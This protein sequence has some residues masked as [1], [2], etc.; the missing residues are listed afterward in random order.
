MI[1]QR[2]LCNFFFLLLLIP[3]SC[4]VTPSTVFGADEEL[5]F[6]KTKNIFLGEAIQSASFGDDFRSVALLQ[7]AYEQHR[8]TDSDE[9]PLLYLAGRYQA[10]G[11]VDRA[12]ALYRRVAERGEGSRS[13]QAW[14][15]FAK[16]AID[17]ARFDMAEQA[18]SHMDRQLD[19]HQRVEKGVI[20]SLVYLH[21]RKEQ[22]AVR[23]LPKFKND[24]NWSIYQR[25]NIAVTLLNHYR[26]RRGA[27]ILAELGKLDTQGDPDK[28]AIRD[29]ANLALGYSL[30]QLNKAKQARKYLS[31]INLNTFTANQALLGMGWAYSAENNHR[32]ALV[33]WLELQK[34]STTIN[35]HLY[36]STLA[37]P[38]GFGRA[39]AVSRAAEA[40][41][42]AIHR[43]EADI[44]AMNAAKEEIRRGILI[45]I[46]KAGS[47]ADEFSWTNSWRDAPV[48]I[49]IGAFVPL[50]MESPVFLQALQEYRA[51]LGLRERYKLMRRDVDGL[52]Q[53]SFAGDLQP[54]IDVVQ[55]QYRTIGDAF[56]LAINEAEKRLNGLAIDVLESHQ[57]QLKEYGQQARFGL[58]QAIE[59]ATFGSG[60]TE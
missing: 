22:A 9:V 11:L 46:L 52:K 5:D 36:E 12:M 45:D 1:V 53:L 49:G 18:L 15:S 33:Y 51:V 23:A 20:Q 16:L 34:S 37:V 25:Y 13:A 54:D 21:Q 35:T 26:N 2:S 44:V 3:V 59:Q 56:K 29:Q 8:L 42:A 50:L 48:R 43:F 38:Y 7:L 28:I 41:D 27:L 30:L 10:L 14:L 40:Y 47:P 57:Q 24:T 32:K 6:S 39:G 4:F 60:V 31:R 55:T 58:A 19:K 17:N